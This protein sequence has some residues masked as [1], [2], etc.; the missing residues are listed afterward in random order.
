MKNKGVQYMLMSS[1]CFAMM[2][3]I[4]KV[5][6]KVFPSVELVFFRN[7]VGLVFIIS[8]IIKRPLQ[9]VGGRFGL[10]TLRGIMGTISLYTLFYCITHIGL[11]QTSTYGQAFPIFLAIFSYFL[12]NDERLNRKQWGAVGLGFV[13]ILLIFKPDV[14]IPIQHHLAGLNYAIFTALSFLSIRELKRYYDTRSVV[15][16]FMLTGVVASMISMILGEWITDH[17]WDFMIGKFVMPQ[18]MQWFWVLLM[19]LLAMCVQIFNTLALGAEK[20]GI[21]GVVS[22]SSIVFAMILGT[23]LG[24]KLP[25]TITILGI[26]CIIASGIYI[27]IK[28][29]SK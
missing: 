17:R 7:I 11:A 24:D 29:D 1:L 14:R 18:G 10:L 16:S 21:V 22:Y 27:S 23:I 5:L 3:A 26:I 25:D 4:A 2:S 12:T 20:A 13:G 19:G 28:K 15:M 6:G 9:Q 8:S